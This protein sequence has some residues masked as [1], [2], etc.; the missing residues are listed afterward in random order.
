MTITLEGLVNT[1]L[2]SLATS[3]KPLANDKLIE[4][5]FLS[6]KGDKDARDYLVLEYRGY[7]VIDESSCQDEL[8]LTI[9]ASFIVSTDDPDKQRTQCLHLQSELIRLL[10]LDRTIGGTIVDLKVLSGAIINVPP[11]NVGEEELGYGAN[12]ARQ[13]ITA[14]VLI[15]A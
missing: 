9:W 15:P 8:D 4:D 14:Q 11:E 12:I 6:S 1:T 2:T 5:I 7:E 13:I 3:L 10:Y